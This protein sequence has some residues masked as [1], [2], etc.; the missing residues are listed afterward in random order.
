[1]LPFGR[2]LAPP[3]VLGPFG[4]PAY[5]VGLKVMVLYSLSTAIAALQSAL[6]RSLT[7]HLICG[8]AV[9]VYIFGIN[10]DRPVEVLNAVVG[11]D[12]C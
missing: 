1:M 5:S 7:F 12:P 11:S 6:A 3:T 10:P 2:Q 9:S 8:P 4:G